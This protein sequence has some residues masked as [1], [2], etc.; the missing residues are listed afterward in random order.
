MSR[1]AAFVRCVLILA[2]AFAA[3]PVQAQTFGGNLLPNQNPTPNP[4]G[5]NDLPKTFQQIQSTA[6]NTRRADQ[7]VGNA[8]A[9][10]GPFRQPTAGVQPPVTCDGMTVGTMYFE[11]G[12][13]TGTR[14]DSG[15]PMG[16]MLIRGGFQLDPLCQL[17]PNHSLRWLQV[18]RE[19]GGTGTTTVDGNPLY[20]NHTQAG[21]DALLFDAPNDVWS[22]PN[23]NAPPT[24]IQFESALVC[25][26]NANPMALHAL[27]SFLWGYNIDNANQT[28]TGE[29]ALIFTPPLT[30]LLTTTFNNEFGPMGTRGQGWTLDSMCSDC[31]RCVPEPAVLI[32]FALCFAPLLNR[33]LRSGMLQWLAA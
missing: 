4:S 31:F 11:F 28:I 17:A 32:V 27:G 12:A 14:T 9:N 1:H 25:F 3:A 5:A 22:P 15:N 13:F 18:Y 16:G 2:V 30:S 23:P 26:D 6:V 8:G 20:P 21:Y 33:R 19:T 24:S 10:G 29:Y 7:Y